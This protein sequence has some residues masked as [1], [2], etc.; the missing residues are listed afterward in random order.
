LSSGF[1]SYYTGLKKF[2][3]LF[4]LVKTAPIDVIP[5]GEGVIMR[6]NLQ[7]PRVVAGGFAAALAAFGLPDMWNGLQEAFWGGY[8]AGGGV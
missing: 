2:L 3:P 4:S 6:P 8:E 1:I 7:Y 5:T